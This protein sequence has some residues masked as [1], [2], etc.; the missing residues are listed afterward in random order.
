MPR[1]HAAVDEAGVGGRRLADEDDV[2]PGLVSQGGDRGRQRFVEHRRDHHVVGRLA[3]RRR[4]V[5]EQVLEGR[6]RP[7]HDAREGLEE[8]L[9]GVP[10][11]STVTPPRRAGEGAFDS[12][13]TAKPRS[14]MPAASE[15]ATTQRSSMASASQP[16]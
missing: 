4:L 2:G 8:L 3:R 14:A 10:A 7:G 12:R 9:E 15:A 6:R 11:G 16:S 13:P 5:V 1:R